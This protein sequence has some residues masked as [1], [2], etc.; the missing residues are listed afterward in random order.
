MLERIQ[1]DASLPKSTAANPAN[2]AEL[3]VAPTPHSTELREK[4]VAP[5]G[6][7][8]RSSTEVDLLYASARAIQQTREGFREIHRSEQD[9]QELEKL[10]EKMLPGYKALKERSEAPAL[11]HAAVVAAGEVEAFEARAANASKVFFIDGSMS[12]LRPCPWIWREP[13]RGLNP[14]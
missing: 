4:A 6:N 11:V 10:Y 9:L 1:S 8:Q 5:A 7:S 12:P 3:V 2:R 14:P 13:W